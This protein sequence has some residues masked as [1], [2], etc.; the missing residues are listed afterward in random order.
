MMRN[1][2]SKKESLGAG[3]IG[4]TSTSES[5][6][7]RDETNDINWCK[8]WPYAFRAKLDNETKIF[9]LPISPQNINI[10]TNF[11]TNVIAT[12]YS[13]VE[14]HS[15]IR[16]YD[17]TIQGTTGFVPTYYHEYDASGLDKTSKNS[18][19]NYGSS[20]ILSDAT[21]GFMRKT[22][23]LINAAKNAA[24]DLLI[25]KKHEAGVFTDNNGYVAFHNFYR[26]LLKHKKSAANMTEENK[27]ELLTFLNYK[28]NNQYS[29]VIQ[30]FALERSAENPMLYN[31]SIQMRAYNLKTI[32]DVLKSENLTDRYTV[33]GLN[34]TKKSVAAKI[35]EKIR[36]AKQA[37]NATRSLIGNAGK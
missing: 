16:Y 18:R 36:S 2:F 21:G 6:K 26:F 14:E 28:D 27:D 11:A 13:T 23:G 22:I 4:S 32:S 20:S 8:S 37:I 15:E 10:I 3:G 35:S 17:I 5:Y 34:D 7:L 33:M 29:C 30:R 12:L 1:P 19:E 9:Y 31:Y 24:S 25:E